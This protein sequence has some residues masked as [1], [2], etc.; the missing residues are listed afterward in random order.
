MKYTS[1]SL[2][3]IGLALVYSCNQNKPLEPKQGLEQEPELAR[4]AAQY[5]IDL[6]ELETEPE[7]NELA[8]LK[9]I[10]RPK[11]VAVPEG[12]VDA[13]QEAIDSAGRHGTV[14]L[15]K[16]QHSESKTIKV[17]NSVTIIGEKGAILTVDTKPS[18]SATALD[19]AFHIL[20]ASNVVICGLEIKPKETAGGT[21]ILLENAPQ[22]IIKGNSIKD[23][24]FSLFLHNG[25]HAKI[26]GNTIVGSS[27]WLDGTLAEVHGIVVANGD[28]VAI[29]KNDISNALFG[30]WAC[31][32]QGILYRNRTHEN[33]IGI[34]LCK[35]PEASFL[36]P[37]GNLVGSEESGSRWFVAKNQSDSNFDT[38]YLVIDGANHNLLV[39][40]KG[41]G[42]AANDVE[43]VGDSERFGFLTPTSFENVAFTGDLL[44]KDCGVDNRVVGSNLVDTSNDPCF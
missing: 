43:L 5:E 7:I 11:V 22:A 28:H 44:T 12:S 40:N 34:I 20:N 30:V 36:L 37:G 19:P 42:N 25:D 33:F 24:Q 15:K 13:L 29:T 14:L 6:A 38:G 16:G 35:V 31:D 10:H 18:P 4:F 1:L 21:A 32:R 27:A 2:A 8:L 23:F 9:G 39:K 3:I 26:Y 41:T 17:T